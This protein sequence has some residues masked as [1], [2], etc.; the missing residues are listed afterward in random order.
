MESPVA[1]QLIRDAI[2]EEALVARRVGAAGPAPHG[3]AFPA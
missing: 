3:F 1:K 2:E